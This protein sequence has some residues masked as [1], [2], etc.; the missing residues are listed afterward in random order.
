MDESIK[1]LKKHAL[2]KI[3]TDITFLIIPNS[4]KI[5]FQRKGFTIRIKNFADLAKEICSRPTEKFDELYNFCVKEFS[6]Y[7]QDKD[8]SQSAFKP[9]KIPSSDP[10][11]N[12]SNFMDRSG[13]TETDEI[14][15]GHVRDG[16]ITLKEKL[17]S[18]NED[19]RWFLY[20]IIDWSINFNQEYIG[21]CV[22]APYDYM[23][24]GVVESKLKITFKSLE[25]MKFA[26]FE[27]EPTWNFEGPHFYLYFST[28]I[29]KFNLFSGICMFLADNYK[30]QQLEKIIIDCDFSVI[31]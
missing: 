1:M 27:T 21:D 14:N 8:N 12:I 24:I 23:A 13:F 11:P 9:L 3:Y 20:K 28:S 6:F 18:L 15:V 5:S 30:A 2:D 17:S 7:F 4:P 31:D 10:N 16:L 29:K 19:Q 25:S 22:A 26:H